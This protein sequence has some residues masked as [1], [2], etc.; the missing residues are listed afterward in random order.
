MKRVAIYITLAVLFL[1]G[2]TALYGQQITVQA[3]EI[4]ND[5]Q[6]L[7]ISTRIVAERLDLPVDGG[8]R[9]V[10]SI[11]NRD[12]RIL[13]PEIRYV[14]RL[15]GMLEKRRETLYPVNPVEPYETYARVKPGVKYTTGYEVSVPYY[16]WM[17]D[18]WIRYTLYAY[19]HDGMTVVKD[20][21]VCSM[22]LPEMRET[23][24]TQE[25][26]QQPDIALVRSMTAYAEPDAG[27]SERRTEKLRLNLSYPA[28]SNEVAPVYDGNPAELAGLDRFMKSDSGRGYSKPRNIYITV[29]G[30]PDGAFENNERTARSR[31]QAMERYVRSKYDMTGV[32]VRTSWVAEDWDGLIRAVE[33]DRRIPR[34]DEV[35]SAIAS[36]IGRDPDTREWLVKVIDDRKPYNYLIDNIYPSL[37]RVEVEADSYPL[38][39][40]DAQIKEMALT[41]PEAL[42]AKEMYRA[43]NFFEEGSVEKKKIWVAA[44]SQYP[45]AFAANNN[46]A[47]SLLRSGDYASALSYLRKIS[48][49][50]RAWANIGTYYYAAGDM[51]RAREYFAKAEAR[52]ITQGRDNLK[53][54][55]R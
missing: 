32:E 6:T 4:S 11:E 53:A 21:V 27:E 9:F 42:G 55:E 52:G 22:A 40:T 24:E 5:G 23:L 18:A 13:L 45:E 17:R 30:S 48:G 41:N 31:A 37:R 10:F 38:T 46:M 19:G 1:T 36:G 47:V 3:P 44:V 25:T 7:V 43:A 35:L 51:E 2:G 29:Y 14:S 20:E 28:G 39:L 49:D 26:Q 12:T 16:P 50:P 34:R 8:Y 15:R 33:A 54:M